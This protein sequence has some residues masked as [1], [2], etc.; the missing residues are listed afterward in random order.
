[1]ANLQTKHIKGGYD[2][3][4]SFL[5]EA[6]K[7]TTELIFD[8]VFNPGI[9]LD[10]GHDFATDK[11]VFCATGIKVLYL[12]PKTKNQEYV[13]YKKTQKSHYLKNAQRAKGLVLLGKFKGQKTK[14]EIKHTQ[15]T[16]TNAFGGKAVGSKKESKGTIFEKHFTDR[17]NECVN[18]KVCKGAYHASAGWL[19]GQVENEG[20]PIINAE[21]VGGANMSRPLGGTGDNIHVVPSLAAAH[22]KILT[23][24][25]L[26][27]D[28]KP[29]TYL[30]LKLGSSTTF[31]NS[32][33]KPLFSDLDIQNEL[34]DM[35]DLTKGLFKIFGIK[36][37]PFC[38]VFNKYGKPGS[39][40]LNL[41]NSDKGH[42]TKG[43]PNAVK[44]FLKSAMGSGYWMIHAKDLGKEV[45]M[46]F[47]DNTSVTGAYSLVTTGFQVLYGGKTG[48]G[49]RV[50]V[51]FETS[52]FKFTLNIR[53][54]A[55]GKTYPTNVM[56]DYKTKSGI[57]KTT[58]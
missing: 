5:S 25:N 43:N 56:L 35:N 23:D 4:G 51:K 49:K 38:A 58:L 55:G 31:I 42:S 34:Q 36:K 57:K 28:S 3:K 40:Q 29:P 16:K 50:D 54:K 12:M 18:G 32:G 21:A 52:A 24:V 33:S 47:M 11:G 10:E 37:G 7:K 30:S 1:M 44:K 13:T 2:D 6:Y 20:R 22:A 48:D 53:S 39:K 19:V 26:N 45:S 46:Y 9:N 41:K 14:S 15:L 17:I 8:K 27:H